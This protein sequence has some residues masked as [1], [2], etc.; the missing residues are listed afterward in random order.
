[1]EIDEAIQFFLTEY[2]QRKKLSSRTYQRYKDELDKFYHF[3]QLNEAIN[4]I[5]NINEHVIRVYLNERCNILSLSKINVVASQIRRFFY[6]L[7]Q[8]GIIE[9]DPGLFLRETPVRMVLKSK[10]MTEWEDT[11]SGLADSL[12]KLGKDQYKFQAVIESRGEK[13]WELFNELKRRLNRSERLLEDVVAS[14]N[15]ITVSFIKEL[16]P[17]VDGLEEAIVSLNSQ[18]DKPDKPGFLKKL[19]AKNSSSFDINQFNE[20]LKLIH[21]RLMQVLQKANVTVIPGIGEK[22]NPHE[23]IAIAVEQRDDVAENTIVNEYL[24]GYRQK[25]N[26]LRLAEVV[27]AKRIE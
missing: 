19:F 5:K 18:P 10:E 3:L 26:V 23:H 24:K 13:E 9:N 25:D 4:S 16:L 22:F 21:H 1:L 17:V 12:K 14:K 2:F 20:G 27:V 15:E 7:K 6:F 8:E 11:L